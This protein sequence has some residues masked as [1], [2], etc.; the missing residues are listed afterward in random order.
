MKVFKLMK[1]GG[2]LSRV[3]GFFLIEAKTLFSIAFL[4]FKNGSREAYHTHAFNAI[5]WVLW[6][7]LIER[8]IDGREF[9]YTPSL[10]PI[11]TPRDRFHKVTSEGNT[12]AITFR[13]PWIAKWKEFLPHLRAFIT[14]THGRKEVAA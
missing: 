5:S 6:G 14:L 3:W 12:L 9:V 10:I 11:Y 2:P 1:D 13:G 4:Y 8:T 7:K